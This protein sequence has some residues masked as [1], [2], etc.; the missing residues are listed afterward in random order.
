MARIFMAVA[1]E[2]AADQE[3]KQKSQTTHRSIGRWKHG[4]GCVARRFS[5]QAIPG[6][7]QKG[8]GDL[9]KAVN[10]ASSFFQPPLSGTLG[11]SNARASIYL[12]PIF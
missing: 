9:Q 5:S 2:T 6:D 7:R 3:P 11:H 8:D 1:E 4:Q 10:Q 12:V